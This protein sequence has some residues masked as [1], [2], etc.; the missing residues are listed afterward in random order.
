MM[1]S[2]WRGWRPRAGIVIAVLL[3]LGALAVLNVWLLAMTIDISPSSVDHGASSFERVIEAA[4]IA[5]FE[6][7]PLSSYRET[8]ARPLF[9]PNRRPAAATAQPSAEPP[10]GSPPDLQLVGVMM[11]A[12]AQK[13]ALIRSSHQPR[14]R[15]IS[16]GGQI[17]G[18]KLLTI[19]ASAVVIERSGVRQELKLHRPAAAR[20]KR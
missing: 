8:E 10:S 19:G 2:T 5:H 4:A 3:P 13:R 14:A 11:I 15:W 1:I 18:W 20:D 17:D 6:A 9:S 16:E 12:P 7:K